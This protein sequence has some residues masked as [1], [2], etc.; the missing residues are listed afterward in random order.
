MRNYW[1]VAAESRALTNRP[2]ARK[3]LGE[4][5][6]LFRDGAGKAA[7]LVDRCPHRNVQLSLGA[8]TNGQLQCPYH[9]WEFDGSGACSKI[10]SLIAGEGIPSTAKCGTYPVVE[11]H[12]YLWVWVGDAPPPEGSKPFAFP[13]RDEPGWAYTSMKPVRIP[14][15]V[16][17]VV[18]NFIDTSHTGYV[19][20]GLFRT[21]ASHS[22]RTKV[23]MVE[24]G[25][26][27]DIDEDQQT[28]SLLGK[29]LVSK[30]SR[31]EHQDRFYLPST[32]RVHYSFGPERHIIGFQVC[33]PVDDLETDV[34]V[35]LTWRFA[36]F[37]HLMTPFMPHVGKVVLDQDMGVLVNQGEVIKQHGEKFV[38]CP[39]DTANL[40]IRAV[41][42]RAKKGEPPLQREKAVE[43]RL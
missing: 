20:G 42:E 34:Y 12:G 6:V 27:I 29:L 26:V 30:G 16:E 14:N 24:D 4:P 23:Q 32:V 11:Q 36:P 17:N 39:A 31:V 43:Y 18:E 33:T 25:V 37:T 8:V 7:A 1:Y 2:L 15:S 5:I 13:H 41:R 38:S 22:A 21:P 35:Y 28:D 40:W 19:H 9:G 10:P 3:I